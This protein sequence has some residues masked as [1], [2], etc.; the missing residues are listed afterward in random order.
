MWISHRR[1]QHDQPPLNGFLELPHSIDLSEPMV[2]E[3][4]ASCLRSMATRLIDG[5]VV[6][7]EGLDAEDFRDLLRLRAGLGIHGPGLGCRTEVAVLAQMAGQAQEVY[8]AHYL[9]GYNTGWSRHYHSRNLIDRLCNRMWTVGSTA[10]GGLSIIGTL[11]YGMCDPRHSLIGRLPPPADTDAVCDWPLTDEAE[12]ALRCDPAFGPTANRIP[13]PPSAGD[14]ARDMLSALCDS[15]D[16]DRVQAMMKRWEALLRAAFRSDADTVAD[17]VRPLLA[18]MI[19]I[20]RYALVT[21]AER[22]TPSR[23]RPGPEQFRTEPIDVR[24]DT[25]N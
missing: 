4:L 24:P 13:A 6:T 21:S 18:A 16:P 19:R 23:K 25:R 14:H 2:G 10:P 22:R 15:S 12:T 11:V 8:D 9:D 20:Y 7:S 5:T 3:G 17:T 1:R